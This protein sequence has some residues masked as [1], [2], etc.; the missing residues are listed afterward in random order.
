MSF[1][2]GRKNAPYLSGMRKLY[3]LKQPLTELRE[4]R[5]T[6]STW[7]AEERTI[8]LTW[9]TGAR[10]SG[11]PGESPREA[12][13]QQDDHSGTSPP[14]R[15]AVDCHAARKPAGIAGFCATT[16]KGT[17]RWRTAPFPPASGLPRSR[18]DPQAAVTGRNTRVADATRLEPWQDVDRPADWLLWRRGRR[19]SVWDA[20]AL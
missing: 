18:C 11:R 8:D 6:P 12:R 14:R 3:R 1:S 7:N 9:S 16:P 4:G 13:V 19:S 20:H 15:V 5:L 2:N 17:L 10:A